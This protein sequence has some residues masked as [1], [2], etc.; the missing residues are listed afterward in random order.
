[1]A[2]PI[3]RLRERKLVQWALAY[4]AG[5]WVILEVFG[6]VADR[7][8][9]PGVLVRGATILLGMGFLL[10][11]VLAWYHGEKGRQRVSG[12]ELVWIALL[13]AAAGVL[14]R[15]FAPG[16]EAGDTTRYAADDGAVATRFLVLLPDGETLKGTE[17]A[18]AIS[19]EG[20]TLVYAAGHGDTTRLYL[21][22]LDS[23]EATPIPGTEG[24]RAPF[25]SPDGEWV[26]FFADHAVKKVSLRGGAPQ[27]VVED[28]WTPRQEYILSG[29]WG[30]DDL[31]L[32][33]YPG[34]EPGSSIW[35]VSAMGG[36]PTRLTRHPWNEN[37]FLPQLLPGGDHVLHSIW[38]ERSGGSRIVA[39]SLETGEQRTLLEPGSNAQY[40]DTGHLVYQLGGDLLAV[41]FDPEALEVTGAAVPVVEGVLAGEFATAQF[42]VS[43]SGTL[44]YVPAAVERIERTLVWVDRLGAVEPVPESRT[45]TYSPRISREGDQVVFQRRPA[46]DLWLL[47][48]DRG[49]QGP[50]MGEGTQ[51]WWFEW[52]LEGDGLV[53]NSDMHGTEWFNLYLTRFGDTGPPERLTEADFHQMPQDWSRDGEVLFF[54]EGPDPVAGLDIWT[55]RLPRE[56]TVETDLTPEPLIRTDASEFHPTVSP[57]GEWLAYVSDV[58]GRWE[59]YATPYPGP[60]PAVQI[61]MQG[62]SEP[63][64]SPDG[65]TLYYRALGE[66]HIARQMMAVSVRPDDSGS[67]PDLAVGRPTVLFDGPY[68]QCSE[69]GRSYDLTPDG[70]R[71][72]MINDQR[73]ELAAKQINV[74]VNWFAELELR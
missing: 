25:F 71:F 11:L 12:P 15:V 57:D 47:D 27:T 54:T 22:A 2:S 9:W 34:A 3:Q 24:A 40:V 42:A 52:T 19:R 32:L 49:T 44:A 16:G 63:S 13:L 68:F 70:E 10:V 6:F 31:L 17:P 41:P 8:A 23:F 28:A 66:R 1:M 18:L 60:G 14:L 74:V 46:A 21:R 43:E 26:G 48:L 39:T 45:D 4:L 53:F 58:S 20:G 7:F 5:G 65:G 50:V 55:L 61:S 36:T 37:H 69:Y 38:D 51:S 73:P 30:A 29:S 64:W 35:Q 56:R 59:V 67:E 62:G 33:S 72:L